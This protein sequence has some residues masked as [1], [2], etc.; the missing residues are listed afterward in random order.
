MNSEKLFYHKRSLSLKFLEVKVADGLVPGAV[1][2]RFASFSPPKAG[3][4]V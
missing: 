4:E 3:H 2:C 1:Q